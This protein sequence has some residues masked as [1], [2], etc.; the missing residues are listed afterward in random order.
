MLTAFGI[1]TPT[2]VTSEEHR[3]KRFKNWYDDGE[4]CRPLTKDE[5]KEL[6]EIG[7]KDWY[8]WCCDNW[9]TKWDACSSKIVFEDDHQLTLYFETAWAPP[10][11]VAKVFREKYPDIETDFFYKEPGMRLCGWIDEDNDNE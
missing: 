10:E 7:Y 11:P 1:G 2:V 5:L 9:G 4:V 8:E 6:A 3:G